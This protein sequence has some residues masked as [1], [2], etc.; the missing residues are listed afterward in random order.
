MSKEV[1]SPPYPGEAATTDNLYRYLRELRDWVNAEREELN[2]A[3]GQNVIPEAKPLASVTVYRALPV[4][5]LFHHLLAMR[6][7]REHWD[8]LVR[9][10]EEEWGSR[11]CIRRRIVLVHAA[12]GLVNESCVNQEV[13]EAREAEQMSVFVQALQKL[14]FCVQKILEP[15]SD[16]GL[17]EED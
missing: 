16:D 17:F 7:F 5:R 10:Y 14:G 9:E 2:N 11:H 1:I 13:R 4:S 15:E 3:A 12:V 8:R 6:Q